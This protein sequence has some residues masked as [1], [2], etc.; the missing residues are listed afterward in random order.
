MSLTGAMLQKVDDPHMKN[1]RGRPYSFKKLIQF[2]Q[3]NMVLDLPAQNI[4]AFLTGD[5]LLVPF[6]KKRGIGHKVSVT[7]P[8]KA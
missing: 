2:S 1:L 3:G 6:T 4:D 5:T 8:L 7:N